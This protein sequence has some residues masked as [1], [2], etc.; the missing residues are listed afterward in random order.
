[1]KLM[2]VP[3]TITIQGM[4]VI[5]ILI[6]LLMFWFLPD[7]VYTRSITKKTDFFLF[8]AYTKELPTGEF[9]YSQQNNVVVT[10]PIDCGPPCPPIY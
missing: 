4:C 2:A 3:K 5:V 9:Y 7:F 6:Q 10:A 8:P 1:M